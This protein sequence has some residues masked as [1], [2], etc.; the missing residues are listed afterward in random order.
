MLRTITEQTTYILERMDEFDDLMCY[1]REEYHPLREDEW[2][3]IQMVVEHNIELC[4]KQ[5]ELSK[6]LLYK[7]FGK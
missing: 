2:Q 6:E 5:T 4:S 1:P 3:Y 7:T